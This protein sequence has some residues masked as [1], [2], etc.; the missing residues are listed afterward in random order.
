MFIY[1]CWSLSPYSWILH[2]YGDV[3]IT[4]KWLQNF[5]IS[6]ISYILYTALMVIW[7][8]GFFNVPHLLWHGPTLYHGQFRGP[9]TPTPVTERFYDIGLLQ[10]QI[11]LRTLNLHATAAVYPVWCPLNKVWISQQLIKSLR[12]QLVGRVYSF[13]LN[14]IFTT[15]YLITCPICL[16]ILFILLF[17]ASNSGVK[18]RHKTILYFRQ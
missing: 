18:V 17:F 4:G 9:V 14:A 16:L 8:W 15:V 1:V 12:L 7:Q 5:N 10:P 11:E 6:Y 3:T 13:F 2:S